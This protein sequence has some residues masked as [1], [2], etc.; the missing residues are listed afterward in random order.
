[1][2]E[3]YLYAEKPIH[4]TIKEI[5]VDFEIQTISKEVIKKVNLIN[6]NILL[7]INE[8]VPSEL[9]ELLLKNNTVIFFFKKKQL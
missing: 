8:N 9:N 5:F 1:M 7:L 2:K 3:F 4:K 6:K